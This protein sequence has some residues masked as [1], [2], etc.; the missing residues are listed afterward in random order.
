MIALVL[1][2]TVGLVGIASHPT[3]PT[4]IIIGVISY[5]KVPA[6]NYTA[7]PNGIL[8]LPLGSQSCLNTSEWFQPEFP[9]SQSGSYGPP[10]LPDSNLPCGFYYPYSS[11]LHN[12]TNATP[13]YTVFVPWDGVTISPP[14]VKLYG[15]SGCQ[16]LPPINHNPDCSGI[17]FSL[18][19]QPGTYDVTFTLLY[20][21]FDTN[22][23][24]L[25]RD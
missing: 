19:S 5:D 20:H 6:Q 9:E 21:W 14:F 24:D 7:A 2:A 4:T 3:P 22:T 16:N 15:T 13:A 23:T 8:P 17:G 12:A 25:S 1:V 11:Y 18:P 10:F